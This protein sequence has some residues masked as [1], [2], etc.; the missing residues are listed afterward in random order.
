MITKAKIVLIEDEKNICSFIER[1][2]APQGYQVTSSATGR[3]GL[4]LINSLHPDLI[5]LDLG[6]PDMDGL[7]IIEQVRTWSAAPIIVVSART[8][9][10][11]KV[12]ALDLGADD[13]ITKPFGT[14]ELM[15]R[16]RTALRHRQNQSA[17][18]STRYEV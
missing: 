13:Y 3:E 5:L 16:I 7:R 8:L 15:A 6:L 9:E 1:I 2:L 11:S 12:A 4:D 14:A 10:K 18:P 17:Y